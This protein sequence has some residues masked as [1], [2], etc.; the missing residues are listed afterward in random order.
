MLWSFATQKI[1]GE[2]GKVPVQ[3]HRDLVQN[4]VSELESE[5][6]A[7]KNFH[8][9]LS[10][11]NQLPAEILSSI[12]LQVSSVT[13]ED[14]LLWIQLSHV[15][16]HWRD[17]ALDCAALWSDVSFFNH[18]L[19][20][21]TM[22]SRSKNAPLTVKFDEIE[23]QNRQLAVL[24][25][26]ADQRH[27]LRSLTL[28]KFG[29]FP[30]RPLLSE[31]TAAPILEELRLC[32]NADNCLVPPFLEGGAPSLKHLQISGC[33]LK[34]WAHLPL[35]AEMRTLDLEFQTGI[36]K[37]GKTPSRQD[38]FDSLQAMPLLRKLRLAGVLPGGIH[39]EPLPATFQPIPCPNLQTL[40]IVSGPRQ[41]IDFFQ[42]LR[43][44]SLKE[45]CIS[46]SNRIVYKAEL[47]EEFLGSLR[48]L[49]SDVV[50]GGFR[51]LRLCHLS[52]DEGSNRSLWFE[53]NPPTG[54]SRKEPYTLILA[55]MTH[56]NIV[57]A[58]SIIKRC[59]DASKL[60]VLD[61]LMRDK[62]LR[63]VDWISA[64][65]DLPEIRYIMLDDAIAVD[66]LSD[67]LLNQVD[68]GTE[69]SSFIALHTVIL[70][71]CFVEQGPLRRLA[72]GLKTRSTRRPHGLASMRVTR[73]MQGRLGP[74]NPLRIHGIDCWGINKEEFG[75]LM[76]NIPPEVEIVW[77]SG[78]T[79]SGFVEG[80]VTT[81]T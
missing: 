52:H 24:L 17:V 8:N 65:G 49:W 81:W 66:H 38:L 68:S 67:A 15:C 62:T 9:T 54:S 19:F 30:L 46:F 47:L 56:P 58:M 40:E 42:K 72:E 70:E 20:A 43:L 10:P 64:F 44:P 22:L 4:R 78:R 39:H 33:H 53:F 74:L 6:R 45:I 36:T 23:V 2:N 61:L 34:K 69:P 79:G 55:N 13:R 12:F 41:M 59:W 29:D 32:G 26:I 63:E 50:E 80:C 57:Q 21:A 14:S 37:S 3:E 18:G 60:R 76:N 25:K 31:I 28:Q 16:Q 1:F 77:D 75:T 35:G 27:R 71:E 11:I 51:T 7:L 48:E 73:S 5:I